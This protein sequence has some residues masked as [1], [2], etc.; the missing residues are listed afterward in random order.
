MS[1]VVCFPVVYSIAYIKSLCTDFKRCF[2]RKFR[3]NKYK[4]HVPRQIIVTFLAKNCC[5]KSLFHKH[6]T[7]DALAKTSAAR[8]KS[9][10]LAWGKVP[11]GSLPVQERG[12]TP[13]CVGKRA[14]AHQCRAAARDHPHLRGEKKSAFCTMP[15]KN[16]ITPT[17]VGKSLP[18]VVMKNADEDHPHLRGEKRARPESPGLTQ[19]SPPLAWGKVRLSTRKTGA[20][21]ITPTCVGKRLRWER[22]SFMLKDHP[23]LRGEKKQG[24][25]FEKISEGSPP[26]TWGK[27]EF[28]DWCK[29]SGRITPTYVGKSNA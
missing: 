28:C 2:T 12:I 22:I 8:T 24:W 13:T 18:S 6:E 29:V 10:P 9:P 5:T 7:Q 14:G 20:I 15:N 26:L 17:C 27:A 11:T 4:S 19:G 1:G 3:Q 16:G 25:N 23:H 21:R